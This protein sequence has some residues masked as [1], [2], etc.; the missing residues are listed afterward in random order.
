MTGWRKI[1]FKGG[2]RND[3]VIIW[4]TITATA[5]LSEVYHERSQNSL[6]RA[7]I[8]TRHS[9]N[10]NQEYYIVD[11]KVRPIF[12][13]YSATCLRSLYLCRHVPS[14]VLITVPCIFYYFVKWP[15][16]AQVIDKLL[17]SCY[18]FRHYCVILREFVVSTLPNYTIMSNALVGNII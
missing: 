4:S 6:F 18:M 14:I 9:S 8:W 11:H 2:G 12:I 1:N 7:K 15:T 13:L 5:L 17:H 3:G 10:M 16:N